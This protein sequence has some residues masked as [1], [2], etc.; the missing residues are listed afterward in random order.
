VVTASGRL[1]PGREPEHATRLRA[2]GVTL[3]DGRVPPFA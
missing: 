1:L 2:E 3:V